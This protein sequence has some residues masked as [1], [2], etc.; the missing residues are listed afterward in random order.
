MNSIKKTGRMAIYSLLVAS[1]PLLASAAENT[2]FGRSISVSGEGS[3]SGPPDQAQISAGVQ[4]FAATVAEAANEN[5]ASIDRIMAALAEAGIAEKH[6]QTANY[7]IWPEQDRDP[8][9]DSQMR[10]VGYRVSNMINVTVE[11]VDKV[12][13]VLGA[14]TNAGA[15]SINGVNFSVEDSAALEQRAREAAMADARERA[16]SLAK[17]ADVSL[18]E[19]LTISTTSG[20]GGPLPMM[21]RGGMEMM[22]ADAVAKPGIA[23][24]Q[25]SVTVQIYVSYAIE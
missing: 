24:G 21:G 25:L 14:V 1:L 2:G 3:A 16:A 22:A 19:V 8:R 6:M 9:D 12:A 20:G 15:N 10:V 13:D 23:P 17:L 7:S 5:Q 18:G 11:D 4:T